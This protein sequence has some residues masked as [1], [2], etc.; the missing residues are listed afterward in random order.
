MVKSAWS[1]SSAVRLALPTFSPLHERRWNGGDTAA[2]SERRVMTPP[3]TNRCPLS[4]SAHPPPDHRESRPP[5]CRPRR[6]LLWLL[7]AD[8]PNHRN[9]PHCPLKTLAAHQSLRDFGGPR[10]SWARKALRSRKDISLFGRSTSG[11]SPRAMAWM[12]ST[13]S[14]L[15]KVP[16]VR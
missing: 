14:R 13:S 4:V 10:L 15:K 12:I 2:S 6:R 1:E 9:G 8:P 7:S 5:N 16:P 11:S 3:Q